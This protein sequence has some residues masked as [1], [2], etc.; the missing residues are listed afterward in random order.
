MPNKKQLPPM[1]H[2][3]MRNTA[4]SDIKMMVAQCSKSPCLICG[5]VPYVVGLYTPSRH[6][7][8]KYGTPKGKV[9]Q[10][11]YSLCAKC[12][13]AAD[14]YQQVEAILKATYPTFIKKAS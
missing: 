1:I 3:G 5:G 14:K 8:K 13:K 9:R 4:P 10:S 12:T 11:F 6:D 2:R 7:Q